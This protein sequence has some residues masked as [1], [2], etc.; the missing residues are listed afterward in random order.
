MS[1]SLPWIGLDTW[2]GS[3][4]FILQVLSSGTQENQNLIHEEEQIKLG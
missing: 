4:L 2:Q 1:N 3:A